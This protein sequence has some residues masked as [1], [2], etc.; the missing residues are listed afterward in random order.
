[1]LTKY[2][3][4]IL[5]FLL[6]V[7]LS[8]GYDL[9][10]VE[11]DGALV[12][13]LSSDWKQRKLNFDGLIKM[14]PRQREACR[15]RC[16]TVMY[17]D[18]RGRT[19]ILQEGLTEQVDQEF[20]NVINRLPPAKEAQFY[21]DCVDFRNEL[22]RQKQLPG[23]E[24]IALSGKTVHIKPQFHCSLYRNKE[25][26]REDIADV[27]ELTCYNTERRFLFTHNAPRLIP[28]RNIEQL[29]S[30][31]KHFLDENF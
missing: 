25:I 27:A 31:M 28:Q 19:L 1:M 6:A 30:L 29:V 4:F 18:R 26:H 3:L 11:F 14:T 15:Q 2:V 5:S 16:W 20:I 8:Y 12:N 23:V 7:P 24:V 17:M 22:Y 9:P 21:K 10:K 13:N